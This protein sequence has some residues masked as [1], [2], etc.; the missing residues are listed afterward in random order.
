MHTS[1]GIWKCKDEIITNHC[2]SSSQ[3]FQGWDCWVHHGQHGY[4]NLCSTT[5]TISLAIFLSAILDLWQ[6]Y[7]IQNLVISSHFYCTTCLWPNQLHN[8]LSEL[9]KRSNVEKEASQEVKHC[10]SWADMLPWLDYCIRPPTVQ[11]VMEIGKA[12]FT[13]PQVCIIDVDTPRHGQIVLKWID[14]GRSG[15]WV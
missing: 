6:S 4:L 1:S 10:S 8:A 7:F 5:T 9:Q 3:R 11:S 14:L 15:E 13:P 2:I 12:F